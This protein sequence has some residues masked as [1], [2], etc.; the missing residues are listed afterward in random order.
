MATYSLFWAGYDAGKKFAME[1]PNPIPSPALSPTW[2]DFEANCRFLLKPE[3]AF[4]AAIHEGYNRAI[5]DA[6][7]WLWDNAHWKPA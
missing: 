3:T 1:N 4:M 2:E 7:H 5:M 6:M